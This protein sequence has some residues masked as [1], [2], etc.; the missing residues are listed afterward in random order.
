[1]SR[2]R[3]TELAPSGHLRLT[4]EAQVLLVAEAMAQVRPEGEKATTG[5]LGGV[6][7]YTSESQK[8]WYRKE[9]AK[10]L[11][12]GRK[13]LA[14]AEAAAS[15]VVE[16]E[17]PSVAEA[18]AV[19]YPVVGVDVLAGLSLGR[20]EQVQQRHMGKV[21]KTQEELF[22][23]KAVEIIRNIHGP[24]AAAELEATYR[25]QPEQRQVPVVVVPLPEALGDALYGYGYD[26]LCN[27]TE[28]EAQRLLV[29]CRHF[30]GVEHWYA[31]EMITYPPYE[32]LHDYLSGCSLE[33]AKRGVRSQLRLPDEND[34]SH[35]DEDGPH[36]QPEQQQ[37][38]ALAVAVA[39]FE[40]ECD[41]CGALLDARGRCP[42]CL[43]RWEPCETGVRHAQTIPATR[44]LAYREHEKAHAA[45]HV[46]RKQGAE[47]AR[48]RR[49]D[50]AS[51]DAWTAYRRWVD[52]DSFA[53]QAGA[54]DHLDHWRGY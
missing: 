48:Q 24:A 35:E 44:E 11:R 6:E 5:V 51:Q 17:V 36:A 40:P 27:F 46:A 14:A 42:V 32:Y 21:I 39:G 37:A 43:P 10:A 29:L 28:A 2:N 16:P 45:A 52:A 7:A 8:A 53:A 41:R 13:A 25:T 47:P 31:G 9:L 22:R 1:V 18:V 3:P 19:A 34:G 49:L 30:E 33:E 23:H 54:F 15:V 4:R 12:A 50:E 26:D 20:T 38:Q